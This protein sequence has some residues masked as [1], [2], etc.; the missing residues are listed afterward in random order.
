MT[1][2]TAA[3]LSVTCAL[4]ETHTADVQ[5]FIRR[6]YGENVYGAN[7]AYFDWQYRQ[8]PCDW[9][10]STADQGRIPVNAVLD[11]DTSEILAVHVY[12]PFD[13][14]IGRQAGRG[15][16]DTEWINGSGIVGLGR[17]LAA[18]LLDCSDVYAGFGMNDWANKSFEK[19]GLTIYPEINRRVAVLDRDGLAAEMTAAGYAWEAQGL[20][21]AAQVLER[22]AFELMS[23][24][25]IPPHVLEREQIN[26]PFGVTRSPQWLAW[27][28]DRHPF[29]TYRIV[30]ADPDGVDGVAM[31]RLENVVGTCYDA[32]RI[33]EFYS[34]PGKEAALLEAVISYASS[35]GALIVDHFT[36]S[37]SRARQFDQTTGGAALGFHAN[38]RVPYMYQPI[39]FNERNSI[40]MA[41]T[42]AESLKG[43]FE[44]ADF[45]ATK[46]D[47]D[48]DILRSMDT[49]PA[50]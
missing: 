23:T 22:E 21:E 19:L 15:V 9:F 34:M 45:H 41:V 32:C 31:V 49:A 46:G 13:A 27:R 20:P 28:F 43:A 37:D 10:R 47:S 2:T 40:N 38:P 12:V 11:D 18:A 8:V 33:I 7:E 26:T 24:E 4:Y 29:I 6:Y 44:L 25:A 30:A 35:H 39:S 16:W 48:Q 14:R 1:A 5:K 50:M 42:C 3:T 17:K 36:A